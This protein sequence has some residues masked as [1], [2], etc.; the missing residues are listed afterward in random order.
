MTTINTLL[1]TRI[2]EL[3]SEVKQLEAVEKELK[4]TRQEL[5]TSKKLLH[6]RSSVESVEEEEV[7][8]EAP[9]EFALQEEPVSV[10]KE[11]KEPSQLID[12]HISLDSDSEAWD[13]VN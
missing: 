2:K 5:E 3:Q 4:A 8:D 12:M 7:A 11:V 10:E 1:E 9:A 13:Y 6:L